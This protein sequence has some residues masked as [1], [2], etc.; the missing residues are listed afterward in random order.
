MVQ[1]S[2]PHCASAGRAAE[3]GLP[4]GLAIAS[5]VPPARG[6]PTSGRTAWPLHPTPTPTRWATRVCVCARPGAI[7]HP[8]A[9][10][11][12][13]QPLP[14]LARHP[15][16]QGAGNPGTRGSLPG[17]AGAPPFRRA[18][19]PRESLGQTLFGATSA[20]GAARARWEGARG[21]RPYL[22]RRPLRTR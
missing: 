3:A 15:G 20:E 11:H 19:S 10:T 12:A 21:G 4:E 13:T 22:R 1:H 5:A 14:R 9:P 8:P 7:S 6:A 17:V 16:K 2:V 18:L